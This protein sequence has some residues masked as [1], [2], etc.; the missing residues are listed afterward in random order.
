MPGASNSFSA[1]TCQPPAGGLHTG[2]LHGRSG[3]PTP[4]FPMNR[5]HRVLFCLP[6]L[7]ALY[8]LRTPDVAVDPPS[9]AEQQAAP[10]GGGTV[11]ATLS[12]SRS[13]RWNRPAQD[14]RFAAFR[15]WVD[16]YLSAPPES[17]Q[18]LSGEGVRLAAQRQR[19]MAD[20]ITANPES[21]LA[22]AIPAKV[23]AA[24]PE[25]LRPF[26]EESVNTRGNYSVMCAFRPAGKADDAS[27]LIR[28]ATVGGIRHAVFTYG[29][30][31]HY[32]TKAS[33]PINGISLPA[34]A[35][36]NPPA[37]PNGIADRIMALDPSP[38]QFVEPGESGASGAN[39]AVAFAGDILTFSSR[40][41]AQQWAAAAIAGA[42]LDL[43]D[44]AAAAPVSASGY[45]EGTKRFLFLRVRFNDSSSAE[46]D[47]ISQGSAEG[48]M[49][50]MVAHMSEI[51]YGRLKIA[52]LGDG[53]S[54]ITPP[55]AI[56]ATA[57]SYNDA[58]LSRLY[59]DARNAAAAAGYNLNDYQF[60][61]VF[62]GGRPSA[63]YA[64]LAYVGGIGIHIAN[65][66]WGRNILVH[67]LGHNLGLPH[68]HTWDTASNSI[69]GDGS[70]VEYG[71]GY[72]PM[73]SGGD[74]D[75]YSGSYKRLIDWIPG[76][77]GNAVST[78]GI[79]R[80]YA[81]D[82]FYG[83]QGLRT[84][85][86]SRSGSQ[87]YSFDFKGDR[88]EAE[89]QNG[90]FAHFCNKDGRESYLLD[91]TPRQNNIAQPIG[92]TFTDPTAGVYVTPL[93]R[94]AT[95]PAG[96]DV[97][98][99]FNTPGNRP[100]RGIVTCHSPQAPANAEILF[101]AEASDA[102]GDELAYSWDF[103]DGT[104]SMNNE[105][106]QT[107]TFGA[108]GEYAVQCTVSDLRGG[109]WRRTVPVQIGAPV[110]GQFHITGRVTDAGNKPLSGIRVYT[111]DTHYCW[112][113]SDGS[114]FLAR[115]PAG[116]VTVKARELTENKLAFSRVFPDPLN[117]TVHYS[118]AD[119]SISTTPPEVLTSL[120]PKLST[121]KYNDTG[122]DPGTAWR[123]TA[124][125][126]TA[127]ASGPGMLGYGNGGEGTIVSFGGDAANKRTACY[128]RKSFNVTNPAA[129]EE[130]RLQ[131]QRDDMVIVYL[132]GT[133]IFSD[134]LPDNVSPD[135]VVYSTLAKA[136]VEPNDYLTTLNI[137]PSLL[138]TGTN[139]LA[140][141]VHQVEPTSS[142]LA[143]DAALT[144]VAQAPGTGA[145]AAYLTS[146]ADGAVITTPVPTLTL[147]AE[148]RATSATV[149]KV[150]FYANSTKLGEDTSAP[151]S[152]AW[153]N[154]AAGSHSLHTVSTFSAGSPLT[155]G[156]TTITI[157]AP[158]VPLIAA[159]SA[160]KYYTNNANPPPA[161][162]NTLAYTDSWISGNA[163]LGY[164]DGDEA[165]A[166]TGGPFANAWFRK[167]FH[168]SDPA[169]ITGLMARMV[170]DDAA[171]VYLNGTLV[172]R[173]NLLN[174]DNVWTPQAAGADS[175]ENA[176]HSQ[177][178]DPALLRAG[179][180]LIA[181][182]V[183][184]NSPTSSDLSF[185]FA[186]EVTG[187]T[188][189]AAGVYLTA[190]PT[191]TLPSAALLQA[192]VVPA[193]GRDVAK[194]EFFTT[195]GKIGEAT[196]WPWEFQ[197]SPPAA[198]SY[199]VSARLTDSSGATF[200]ST[201]LTLT[202]AHPSAAS[203]LISFGEKW[204]YLDTGVDPGANW[205]GRTSYDDSSWPEGSARFGYGGDGE[206]TVINAGVAESRPVTAWFR[207]KFTVTNPA[208]F[209]SLRLRLLRDDAAAVFINRTEVVRD[210][211]PDA[212]LS[213][214][215]LATAGVGGA[216]EQIAVDYY[217]PITSLRAGENQIAVEVHQSAANSSDL[218]FDLALY[219]L[220]SPAPAAA[221]VWLT[222]P[223]FGERLHPAN[224]IACAVAFSG[225]PPVQRVEFFAGA[226]E[227][228]E[229][230]APPFSFTWN[231]PLNGSYNLKARA[232]LTGSATLDSPAL[233]VTVAAPEQSLTLVPQG[234]DWKYL[235]TGIVPAANW[236]TAAFNDAAWLT[237]P[238][239]L[240]FGG[241]G[242]ATT[243]TSGRLVYWARR[244]FTIPAGLTPVSATL[245]VQRDDGLAVYL[246]G[247]RIAKF[248]ITDEP[249]RQ[250][251]AAA[252]AITDAAEQE[253]LDV[254]VPLSALTPGIHQLAASIHQTGTT[255]SDT[256]FDMVL[257]GTFLPS[258]GLFNRQPL[259]PPPVT[260]TSRP[261][262]GSTLLDLTLTDQ[263]G[264]VYL[265]ESSAN[266]G[267]WSPVS[268]HILT[269]PGLTIPLTRGSEAKRYYRARWLANP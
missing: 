159:G 104:F 171:T 236:Q 68:A 61:A 12:P 27:P 267:T 8:F 89:F 1:E 148:A 115:I 183:Q 37:S 227:I 20:M 74:N 77:D 52:P 268:T 143:F 45:T 256:G 179:N 257:S 88:G 250:D 154:P 266:L 262:S 126:D 209:T 139:V 161:N 97:A 217:I 192:A 110:A 54:A 100:P 184:Q 231:T 160:W 245:R 114:Y 177:P 31:L 56:N 203:A 111:D 69:I 79:Y 65:G 26:L 167:S 156:T 258:T 254:T 29:A 87:D 176:W 33:V 55:L 75:H 95:Y 230:S 127:W 135:N 9:L 119:F 240:G 96:M 47:T 76:A 128:F 36:T 57:A 165:T 64:G 147:T 210:N 151:Y 14:V 137:S 120:V 109:T 211:L 248:N 6:L 19:I 141:E 193:A 235:D 224:G 175:I 94:T 218:G 162:W 174:T 78:P 263:P 40:D 18:V 93:R 241:D 225:N 146:P 58:G 121:W 229:S 133:R 142:D 59:P 91:C 200:N 86:V 5:F 234:A 233:P 259:S 2:P 4:R 28:E 168:V 213:F 187:S 117:L 226:A 90:L 198:G 155:S 66:Y 17:Q 222:S 48:L 10:S 212:T 214:A 51:S 195:A 164:G 130:L 131:C 194:V 191:V 220:A 264:R 244:T 185:N 49:A 269:A 129:F 247:T 216:A 201:P 62:T 24:L 144:G 63:G 42:E 204:K 170:R 173:S 172:W 34:S 22:H 83:N 219:G 228:G 166:I 206:A 261:G 80:L 105:P 150:E 43:P 123:A 182:L 132:N 32:V 221:S 188:A 124:Y 73:G 238:A 140:A 116:N 223:A 70:N 39:T 16:Q 98:V 107:H 251:S 92:R 249:V 99:Y 237:G 38:A 138:V 30:G 7:L 106:R 118:G 46:A 189:R 181:V 81:H 71:N 23:R 108:D 202:V 232:T 246:N 242:E 196:A 113:D 163:Q 180:N 15:Q 21:A 136:A 215:T 157:T 41:A 199:T 35:A 13:E 265:I 252:S 122:T 125:N 186:L 3:L 205:I 11:P 158:P 44:G 85:R 253:W 60:F 25:A 84:L 149:T 72:D 101:T 260:L 103:G 169:A 82:N 255:S 152:F 134:N 50:G 112:T 102:D 243:M 197:W 145:A 67:E 208:A 153:N 190:P 239:R 207:K 178:L 53:G